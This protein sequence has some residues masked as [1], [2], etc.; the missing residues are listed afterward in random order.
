MVSSDGVPL[1][2]KLRAAERRNRIA[3]FMLVVPLLA[4][5]TFSFVIPI[6]DMLTRSV[7]NSVVV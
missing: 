4:F 2:S 1:K 5:I 6:L 7:D 3:A